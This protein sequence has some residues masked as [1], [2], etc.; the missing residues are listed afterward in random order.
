MQLILGPPG[1]VAVY[2]LADAVQGPI[3]TD[4][5]FPVVALPE[6][7]SGHIPQLV[8]APGCSGLE[9]TDNGSQRSWLDIRSR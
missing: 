4:D 1:R 7:G 9:R 5:G 6:R 8:D 2:V 3:I